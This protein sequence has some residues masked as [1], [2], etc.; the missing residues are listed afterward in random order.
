MITVLYNGPERHK[1]GK[2]YF[3]IAFKY[4]LFLFHKTNQLLILKLIIIVPTNKSVKQLEIAFP[5]NFLE[6]AGMPRNAV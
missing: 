2:M 4:T 5:I 3:E 6:K 1:K